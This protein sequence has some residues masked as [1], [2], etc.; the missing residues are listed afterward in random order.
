MALEFPSPRPTGAD[1]AAGQ[2]SMREN[3]RLRRGTM[4][5]DC[6]T[7]RHDPTVQARGEGGRE[8]CGEWRGVA[9][10][11][12]EEEGPTIISDVIVLISVDAACCKAVKQRYKRKLVKQGEI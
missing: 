9:L 11:S 8:V 1:G 10:V 7:P 2:K 3:W 4:S 5:V 12:G 6:V